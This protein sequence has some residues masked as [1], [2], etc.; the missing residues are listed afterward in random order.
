M[1][2]DDGDASAVLGPQT[3]LYLAYHTGAQDGGGVHVEENE[4]VPALEEKTSC[5]TSAEQATTPSDWDNHT[6]GY[7]VMSDGY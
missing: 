7:L 5:S 4:V 1:R 3:A 2:G 6:L